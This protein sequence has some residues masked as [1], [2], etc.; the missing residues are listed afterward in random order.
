MTTRELAQC[1]AAL[2]M[3]LMLIGVSV[4][5]LWIGSLLGFEWWQVLLVA[6]AASI[7]LV[8]SRGWRKK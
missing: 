5:E 2:F 7:L 8:G 1:L 6:V 3:A 4:L